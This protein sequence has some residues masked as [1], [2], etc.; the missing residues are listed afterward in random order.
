MTTKP[1]TR[2]A[3]AKPVTPASVRKQ[4]SAAPLREISEISR[5]VYRWRFLEAEEA[6]QG[7]DRRND[8]ESDSLFC[9]HEPEQNKWRATLDEDEHY[10][11]AIVL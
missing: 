9:G 1:K 11:Y 6:Y 5:M 3:P 4:E 8:D 10:V 2:K 7:N